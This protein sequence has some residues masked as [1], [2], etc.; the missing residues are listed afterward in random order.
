MIKNKYVALGVYTVCVI[1]FWN[2]L[3][4]LFSRFIAHG[5]YQF[6]VWDN[7]LLPMMLGI[8]TGYFIFLRKKKPKE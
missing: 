6:G 4:F 2:L 5:A 7:I 8:A 1:A 3:E